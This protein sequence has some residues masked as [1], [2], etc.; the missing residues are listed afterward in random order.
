MGTNFSGLKVQQIWRVL[1]LADI[2]HLE[3]KKEGF[4]ELKIKK[5]SHF[6]DGKFFL[7]CYQNFLLLLNNNSLKLVPAISACKVM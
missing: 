7:L 2:L 3:K 4:P 6:R 5:E 1:I